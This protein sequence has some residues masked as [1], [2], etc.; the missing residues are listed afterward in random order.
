MMPGI[1]R[2]GDADNAAAGPRES[3]NKGKVK[4]KRRVRRGLNAVAALLTS[5]LVLGVL[6]IGYGPVPALG[7][8]LDPGAGVWNSIDGAK[9][10][11]PRTATLPGMQ[12]PVTITL[13]SSGVPAVRA[14]SDSDLFE[15]EGYLHAYFRLT[16]LDVE[17]R[18]ATGR[19]AQ[20]QGPA[21]VGSDTF[22]LES[23]LE[24]TA[25]AIWA[26]TDQ[27][28]TE[29]VAL[30]AYS[31]GVN[32]RL[33]E[34][35]RSGG[36]PA[37]FALTGV[38]PRDWT[39]VDSIAVQLLWTQSLDYNISPLVYSVL[40]KALGPAQTMAFFPVMP[41]NPQRPYD[42]GPYQYLGLEPL[43]ASANTDAAAP[44]DTD[45]AGSPAVTAP[46][47]AN[48]AVS[49]PSGTVDAASTLLSRVAAL[50]DLRIN[51]LPDSNAW[52]ANGPATAGGGA[53]MAGDPHLQT[54]LPAFWYQ[55]ALS[56]PETD[57]TGGS[58][59]GTPGV[60]IGRNRSISWSMTDVENQSTLFY[61]EKTSPDHP[62]QYYWRGAWRT[63]QQV[64]YSIPVRGGAAVPLTV[65]LTVHGPVMSEADQVTGTDQVLTQDWMGNYLSHSVG[66]ILAVD[67][68][69]DFGQFK[70]AL[71]GWH[72]PTLNFAFASG[73]GDIG[74]VAAGYFPEV[75]AGNPWQPL[76][77]TGEDDVAGIIPRAATPQVYDP[78]GHVLATANQ[79]PV[80]A[81]YPYYVGT[82]MDTFD[83]GYRADRIY[84]YLES[85]RAMTAADFG[86]LQD[87]VTDVLAAQIVPRLQQALKGAAL[88]QP[89]QA[90][91]G[92]LSSWDFQMTQSSAGASIWWTFWS[93]YLSGVF[94]PWWDA[95]N[96][97]VAQDPQ[98]LT[99]DPTMAALTEDLQM[100]TLND[101]HNAAFSAPGHA[102]GDADSAMRAAFGK[103]VSDLSG[104]L[105]QAPASWSWGQ[106]HTRELPA[107]IGAAGLGYGPAPAG[108]DNWTVNA[109]EGD[110]NSSFGPSWRMVV[111]WSGEESASAWA[112]YPGGQSDDPL[113]P[114]Y[115]TFV[116]DWW[117]GRLR[118][119][120]MV[121]GAA[122][123][124]GSVVWTL[125]PGR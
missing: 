50:P 71:A 106:I 116:A 45:Q 4:G 85:H 49:R 56:S 90:A 40:S 31:R 73:D 120:Q 103:A 70:S 111:S 21:G 124:S 46:G 55:I 86:T 104:Q 101:P 12:D 79:R 38:Y 41:P 64:H 57:V 102:A 14:Q 117:N 6:S 39:P 16:Q 33:A 29:A 27:D 109:A 58:V 32:A 88:N 112:I 11:G 60:A 15:A 72:S 115:E 67:K 36:W 121:G 81:K 98:D 48:G 114:W 123:G 99:I 94:Q 118:P 37:L 66:A 44:A 84:Q 20:L 75:K 92:V 76:D 87:D 22:E 95:T 43:P 119:L 62:N 68:A 25:Q 26:N 9:N 5:L 18:T 122:P 3:E 1:T 78:P 82:S 52:A 61:A 42:T 23:G 107:L 96:V 2:R 47:A 93:D 51:R 35:R 83:T 74:V 125:G 100:W 28:S 7:A 19:L 30:R 91:L 69:R 59:P 17:R 89:E 24:R 65:D 80:T 110:L 10:V 63:M 77:G 97:P 108:G 53:L 113:S 13:D 105:G 54:P 34:L 8:A